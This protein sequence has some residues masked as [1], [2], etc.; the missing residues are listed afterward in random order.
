M[1]T[2]PKEQ[3]HHGDLRNTLIETATQ[4]LP[5][6]GV[7]GLSLRAIAKAAGVSH[8]APY[9]H[10]RDK[11]DL[12]ESIAISGYNRLAKACKN[13]EKHYPS[14]P[15]QQLFE[16]GMG[17]LSLVREQPEMAHL[18][19]SGMLTQD[20]CGEALSQAGANAVQSLAQ[21]IDNGKRLGMYADRDTEDLT[22]TALACVHGIAMMILSG[23]IKRPKSKQQL[24]ALGE[25]I[26]NTL[27][28]G[29]LKR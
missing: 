16:A 1:R 6:Y 24:Q 17:Y 9:R 3:Y 26:S 27:L 18:M 5:K 29:L 7:A 13:A 4:L 21:I 15:Q 25:R 11:T 8:A 10:F 2:Q 20:N 23:L 12:L 22:L 14:S 19:F 28:M